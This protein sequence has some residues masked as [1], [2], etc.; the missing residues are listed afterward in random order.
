MMQC[1]ERMPDVASSRAK[2]PRGIVSLGVIVLYYAICLTYI[3]MYIILTYNNQLHKQAT[4]QLLLLV[5]VVLMLTWEYNIISSTTSIQDILST[6]SSTNIYIYVY[7]HIC[8]ST[9][10]YIYIY[11]YIYVHSSLSL[12]ISGRTWAALAALAAL[13]TSSPKLI[14]TLGFLPPGYSL[15]SCAFLCF[16]PPGE[17]LKSG[18]GITFGVPISYTMVKRNTTGLT[19]NAS[20]PYIIIYLYIHIYTHAYLS[21]YICIHIYIYIYIYRER[22][23]YTHTCVYIY[24]YIYIYIHTYIHTCVYIYIYNQYCKFTF[25]VGDCPDTCARKLRLSG[26]CLYY[27]QQLLLL[28][29]NDSYQ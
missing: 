28:A 26:L 3:D 4:Y 1:D 29:I 18:V 24:I 27:Q 19:P 9:H 22:E 13:A 12:S 7:I 17:I 15:F 10:I 2:A 20:I 11:I 25:S 21:L 5:L 14:P 23:R 16:L 8:V 6:S